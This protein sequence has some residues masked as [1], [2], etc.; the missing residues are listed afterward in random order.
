MSTFAIPPRWWITVAALFVSAILLSPFY[1]V[2]VGSFM[3]PAELFGGHM[4]LWP[5]HFAFENWSVALA[6]RTFK[7]A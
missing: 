3:T 7:I 6:R 2:L 1:W 5:R 4:T